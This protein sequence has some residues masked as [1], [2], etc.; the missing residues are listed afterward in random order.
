MSKDAL[1]LSTASSGQPNLLRAYLLETKYEWLKQFRMPAYFLPSIGFPVMFYLL[2]GSTFGGGQAVGSVTMSTF[3]LATYGAFGAIGVC[4]F[5]FG[6][7]VAVERGQGWLLLK[8]ASP[9]PLGAF[10]TAKIIAS[11]GFVALVVLALF[12]TGFTVGGV[13]LATNVWIELAGVIIAGSLPFCAFGL[14]L[15]HMAGPNSAPAVVNLI[16]LPMAFASGL[17]IP[18]QMLPSFFQKLAVWLPAYHYSQLALKVIGADQGRSTLGHVFYLLGF[19]G[20]CLILAA[21]AWNQGDKKLY[22]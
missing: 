4:L 13:R 2:F 8:R 11:L 10:F 15:G 12:V 18:I 14:L 16:Y 9:M 17:W 22:G 6:V 3:L 19:T 5:G 20:L 21:R 7:G 1:L